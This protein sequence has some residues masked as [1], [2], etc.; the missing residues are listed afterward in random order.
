MK[1]VIVMMLLLAAGSIWGYIYSI[2]RNMITG[3]TAIIDSMPIGSRI[4]ESQEK[5]DQIINL[6]GAVKKIEK[7]DRVSVICSGKTTY[8]TWMLLYINGKL[9]QK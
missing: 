8:R 4:D 3:V 6:G 5:F 1:V 7:D 2:E 9:A